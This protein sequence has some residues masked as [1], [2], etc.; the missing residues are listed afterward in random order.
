MVKYI[1]IAY[2]KYE[3]DAGYG[4]WYLRCGPVRDLFTRL[5]ACEESIRCAEK[6]VEDFEW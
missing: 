1:D 4:Y 5:Y 2:A 3:I 6:V